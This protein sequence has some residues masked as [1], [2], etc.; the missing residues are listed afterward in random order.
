MEQRNLEKAMEIY[1]RLIIGEEVS[2]TVNSDLY[3]SYAGNTEVYDILDTVLKKSNLKLY[4]YGDA[5][6]VCAGAGNKVF[7]FTNDDLKREIGLRLNKELF[8][9]YYMIFETVILFYEN[10]GDVSVREYVKVSDVI[11]AVTA[12]LLGVMKK[13]GTEAMNE[14]E[15]TSFK[16]IALLWDELPMTAQNEDMSTLKAARGSKIG[17]TKLVFNFLKAQN[18]FYESGD[19]YYA[20]GRFRAMVQNYYEDEQ[21]RLFEI[22]RGGERDAA[23]SSDSGQ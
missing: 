6:Y 23:Y 3:D 17:L 1:G 11:E 5:L 10:S 2:K 7:G 15:E 19:K 20:T 14:V 22:A 21:S 16:T 4:E 18:L 13:I 12:G 8:L 9:A